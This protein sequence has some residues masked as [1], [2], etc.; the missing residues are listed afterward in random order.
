[1][2]QY[3]FHL[4]VLSLESNPWVPLWAGSPPVWLGILRHDVRAVCIASMLPCFDSR[5][6]NDPVSGNG[7]RNV[8]PDFLLNSNFGNSKFPTAAPLPHDSRIQH[9]LR[10]PCSSPFELCQDPI[11]ID[12]TPISW[13]S[14]HWQHGWICQAYQKLRCD[15]YL[16]RVCQK[17]RLW[18][19]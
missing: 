19:L 8:Y 4:P 13:G 15:L 9:D 16:A 6:S 3:V 14:D 1:M 10:V 2:Y 5:T 7:C 11:A 17:L 18:S 12:Q